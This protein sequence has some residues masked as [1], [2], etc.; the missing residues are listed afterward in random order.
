MKIAIVAPSPVPFSIGGA[1]Q[2]FLGMHDAIQK[3]TSHQCELVKI[4]TREDNFW[5]LIESYYSFY[6]LDLSHFD[7]II[8]TKYP[9]WMVQHDN[10]FVYMVHPLRGLYDTYHFCNLS[11]E[12]PGHLRTGVVEE[13]LEIIHENRFSKDKVNAVFEKLWLLKERDA[14]YNP[15]TF[16]FPGPFIR[17]IIH[18]FDVFALAPQRIQRY[19]T[20]SETVR[21]RSD[22]FPIGVNVDVIHPPSRLGRF[23]NTG[24]D[25]LFTASR[26]D[27]PKRIDLIINAMKYVPHDIKLKIAGTGPAEQKLRE[28]AQYDK[29]VEFVGF[30][31]ENEL[32]D[33][34]GDSLAVVFTPYDEDY[35]LITLEAMLSNKPVITTT[36]SGGPLELVKNGQSGFVV[37]P[38]P[39][40]IGEK[41]NYCIE[42]PEKARK[43]GRNGYL[44][45]QDITWHKFVSRLLDDDCTRQR[46]KS[47]IL[48][49]ATYSC[50]PPRGGGQHRLYNLYSRLAKHYDVTI[51][52]IIESNKPYQ[53]LILE[54]GLR[55]ICVPQSREHAEAQWKAEKKVGVN[56]YDVA[57]IDY[58]D[59]S[60]EY[61]EMT[62]QLMEHSDIVIFSHPYLFSLSKYLDGDKILLHESHNVEYLLKKPYINN[63]IFQEK[64]S[65]I[66]QNACLYTHITYTTSDLDREHLIRL[67]DLDP[68]RA[69]VVPNGVDVDQILVITDNER[70]KQKE[71][72]KIAEYSTILFVGSWHPPNLEALRFI[73]EDIVTKFQD[74]FFIII[75]SVKDYY[76]QE[77]GKLPDNVLAFGTVEEDEKYELYKLADIAI[78]PMFSGSGTNLKML[79]YM[80]AGIPV[81]TTP[82]GTRG[83]PVVNYEHAIISSPEQ[84]AD[85]IHELISDSNLR[86]RLRENARVLVE[87]DFSWDIIAH[88]LKDNIQNLTQQEY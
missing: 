87:N 48:V 52:S 41:I 40:K 9:S 39:Q 23:R 26:L 22:Y 85:K 27:A 50:Y 3:Y 56:L 66:E 76:L 13:I 1:E 35:G 51:C 70:Q 84:M 31:H 81:I 25:Y 62:C 46:R 30:V 28:I 5:N 78:N 72:V 53:N 67:Y 2:L 17:T 77:Y 42:H 32:L 55:Q 37:A 34:Y 65:T 6:T 73:V 71:S 61:V 58:I 21:R 33:L 18:F 4:P 45:A 16:Q 80:S 38:D 54:N 12:I 24:S 8:S 86:K 79:D 19:C 64:I 44:A 88:E 63:K 83:I 69:F 36:D 82:I 14:H 20:M 43:M 15:E 74:C 59:L 47:K 10:H 68:E 29:R 60:K 7:M 57:M 11:S 49:L 75:G